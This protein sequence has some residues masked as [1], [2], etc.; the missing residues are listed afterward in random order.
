LPAVAITFEIVFNMDYMDADPAVLPDNRDYLH[1]G[2]LVVVMGALMLTLL[3]EALDQTV[4]GTAMPRIIGTLHGF[5]RY[6]WA[7]TAYLL[8][9]TIMIPIAGKLSDQFGRKWFLV[10]GSTTFLTGS[11]LCGTSQTINQLIVFRGVQGLGAGIGIS[12]VFAAVADI[13]PAEERAKWQGILGSVYGI[14]SVVGPALGGWLSEHG[15]LL[16][17]LVTDS[18]RWRWVFLVNLPLGIIALGALLVYLPAGQ[19]ARSH[20]HSSGARLHRID[21]AGSILVAVATVSLLLGLTWI[22]EGS[23]TWMSPRVDAVFGTS[24]LSYGA[25][26]LVERRAS[27]PVLS[28]DLFRNRVFAANATLTLFLWM[29]LFGVA[30]YIPLFLQGVLGV[31]PTTAGLV[32]TPFSISIV[33]GNVLA[34]MTISRLKRYHTVAIGG[35][36]FMTI[37]VTLLSQMTLSVALILVTTYVV[38]AG[39]GMGI[40][41]TATSVVV[42]TSLPSTQMGAGFGVVRYLGQIG[43]VLGAALVGTVVNASLAAELQQRLP[44]SAIRH[45]ASEGVR[46][47]AGPQTLVS[48]HFR[49]TAIQLL[50][51]R[52]SAQVPPGPDHAE[53]LAAVVSKEM[54]LL[55]QGFEALRLSLAVAIQHGLLAA[56]LF[57]AGAV[58]AAVALTDVSPVRQPD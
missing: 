57:C 14:S 40:L 46:F 50:A 23:Q 22:G 8:A 37:G 28:L 58:V 55:H 17:P 10:A 32:L 2:V 6:T 51:E 3:L 29:T 11:V 42:Q 33:L 4:V 9:S 31:S 30:L 13:F 1:G 7:V 45:L 44:A 52:A 54:A 27:E 21:V 34:G 39:F 18:T 16:S 36:V 49:R 19:S 56:L 5:D 20:G 47:S 41:F 38:I 53:R 15:P 12:L 35:A 24:L 25:F 48:P 43:G 26:I